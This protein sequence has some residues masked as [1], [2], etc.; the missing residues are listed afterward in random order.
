MVAGHGAIGD[1]IM[2]KV[3]EVTKTLMVIIRTITH[4]MSLY[5][6][7]Y[8]HQLETDLICNMNTQDVYLI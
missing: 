1:L 8:L 6:I 2:K 5:S 7:L 3:T 4:K